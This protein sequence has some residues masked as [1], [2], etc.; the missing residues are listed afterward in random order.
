MLDV[1]TCSTPYLYVFWFKKGTPSPYIFWIR[2]P[3][4][5]E[6]RTN[7]Y[8]HLFAADD[9]SRH[10]REQSLM[11]CTVSFVQSFTCYKIR[12]VLKM[13]VHYG[14]FLPPSWVGL[15]HK[16]RL[17]CVLFSQQ[18]LSMALCVANVTK[19]SANIDRFFLGRR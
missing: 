18:I 9:K 2:R 12:F 13:L 5:I 4:V 14:Y 19:F 11:E 3:H 15:V 1:L 16:I 8:R 10:R 6:V 7:S 17:F